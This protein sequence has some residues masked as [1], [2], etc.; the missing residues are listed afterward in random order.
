MFSPFSDLVKSPGETGTGGEI[1]EHSRCRR[2]RRGFSTPY[3]S[4]DRDR[5]I[6][7]LPTLKFLTSLCHLTCRSKYD[8]VL[9][10]PCREH[11]PVPLTCREL[12]Y[13]IRSFCKIHQ[14]HSSPWCLGIYCMPST[15]SKLTHFN[16]PKEIRRAPLAPFWN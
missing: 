10:D 5:L 11:R 3:C 6:C 14:D 4:P 16:L 2:G 8:F 13:E 7:R 9:D 15:L 12:D 1:T